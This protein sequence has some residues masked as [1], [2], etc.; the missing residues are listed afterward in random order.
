MQGLAAWGSEGGG[1][2]GLFLSMYDHYTCAAP[3]AEIPHLWQGLELCS[4]GWGGEG[5]QHT[6]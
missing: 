4:E 5:S 6:L 3:V 2:L 1:H